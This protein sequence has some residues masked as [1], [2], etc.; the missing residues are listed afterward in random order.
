[1]SF[2]LRNCAA[3]VALSALTGA[4]SPGKELQSALQ[5]YSSLS[6]F[7]SLLDA[8]PNSLDAVVSDRTNITV[9][10][11]TDDAIADYLNKTGITDLTKIT[12]NELQ[13]F[14]SYHTLT[15][16]LQG[17][18]F[19]DRG[20]TVPTLL[21]DEKFN[22]RTAGEFL[23]Q[24]FGKDATGQVLFA[25]KEGDSVSKRKRQDAGAKVQLR[26]GLA[27]DA[28]MTAVDGAWGPNNGSTFQIVNK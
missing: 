18:D 3:I 10:I 21:K 11:P 19:S 22:N 28:E 5:P 24:A 12:S 2:I 20:E 25:T 7:R 26:A 15:A 17:S 4:Q 9:L 27:E 8:A 23:Q 14:L 6:T 13:N 1:M 16:S